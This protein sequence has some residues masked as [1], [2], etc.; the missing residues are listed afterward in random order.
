V[1]ESKD[2]T[3]SACKAE[4][5]KTTS[6]HSRQDA[7]TSAKPLA[8]KTQTGKKWR[9]RQIHQNP[10]AKLSLTINK[11]HFN[12][13]SCKRCGLELGSIPAILWDLMSS[14]AESGH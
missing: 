5:G 2:V 7:P 4:I 10:D 12:E 3:A 6:D 11:R 9:S 1:I 13:V 14:K 8:I